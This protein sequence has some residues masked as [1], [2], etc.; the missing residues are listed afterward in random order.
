MN[1]RR[2]ALLIGFIAGCGGSAS[3]TRSSTPSSPAERCTADHPQ[4]G[5]LDIGDVPNV[6]RAPMDGFPAESLPSPTA[7]DI[8]KNCIN[9]AGTGCDASEFITRGAA[10]CLVDLHG[11]ALGSKPWSVALT[12]RYNDKRVVWNFMN[13]LNDSGANGY[14]GATLS[15][16]AI[17][18]TVLREGSYSATP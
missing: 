17:A 9:D 10:V 4:G 5:L 12:Y 7:E 18:G 2:F 11:F 3:E 8:A 1:S 13:V 14:S 6:A 16:D 15:L